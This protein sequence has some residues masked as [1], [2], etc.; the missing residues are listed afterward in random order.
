M[1]FAGIGS[2]S[3]AVAV[4]VLVAM[5]GDEYRTTTV[6]VTAAPLVIVPITQVTFRFVLENEPWVLVPETKVPPGGKG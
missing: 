6:L 1:L 3:K 2:F 5:P 4:T